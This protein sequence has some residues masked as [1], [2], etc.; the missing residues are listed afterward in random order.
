MEGMSEKDLELLKKLLSHPLHFPDEFKDWLGDFVAQT[1]PK[2]PISH[3][4]GFKLEW[5]KVATTVSTQQSPSTPNVY[6][7]LATVGPELEGVSDGFYIV[8]FGAFTEE[9]GSGIENWMAPSF[10][11]AE[12]SDDDA[13]HAAF[14]TRPV[15]R[16]VLTD[17]RNDNNNTITMQYK[18]DGTAISWENRWMIA[19]KVT[20]NG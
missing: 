3:V 5:A 7:D 2:L 10:N 14:G 8:G 1:I 18:A 13:A 16:V 9:D 11:G 20:T 15:S 6:V 12:P 17:L 4:Y 19:M